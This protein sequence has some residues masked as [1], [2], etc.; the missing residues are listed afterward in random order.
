MSLSKRLLLLLPL[1]TFAGCQGLDPGELAVNTIEGLARGAC[2]DADNCRNV[3]P[4]GSTARP[5]F[6]RCPG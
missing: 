6:H 5:P 2:A 1:M 4:D 3:C